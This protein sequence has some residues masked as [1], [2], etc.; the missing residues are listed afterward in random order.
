MRFNI[1][2]MP[3][4]PKCQTK[5]I[6]LWNG[7]DRVEM[8]I[9]LRGFKNYSCSFT[10]CWVTSDRKYLESLNK[11]DAIIFN[12][13]VLHQLKTNKLPSPSERSFEQYYI[14]F[15]Q[16]SP[17]YHSENL[18]DYNGYF[19]WTMSY[20]PN[21]DILY[22]YGK[23]EASASLHVAVNYEINDKKR[24]LVAWF[25]SHCSTQSQRE[26]Y[27]KE[28][29]KY[30]QIDIYGLC[31][32]LKC[33]WNEKT[34]NSQPECYKALQNNYKFYLSLENSL[35]KGYVTE[36]LYSILKLDVVPVVMG[37]ANYSVI[38]PPY[39]YIDALQ[40]SPKELADYLILLDSNDTLY[41]RYFEWKSH[42]IIYSDYEEIGKE[43]LCS[44]CGK[45]NIEP[46]RNKT[47]ADLLST[48]NPTTRCL[49]PR[50]MKA[51]RGIDLT[52]I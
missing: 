38:A 37:N 1:T 5:N 24:K 43:A 35:C 31:G 2:N 44:L 46:D 30:I 48:W 13:A 9:L 33:G 20:L 7:Y 45:L 12:M 8:D 18:K 22:P 40:Y 10:N 14:F 42:Y 23:A 50:Y 28:L 41:N 16:E 3:S 32:P 25:V 47:P 34:G 52:T 49:N 4:I 27:V 6:L 29:Q 51:F 19:N 36:K 21:S 26:K 39:S 17:F 11:F 15:T